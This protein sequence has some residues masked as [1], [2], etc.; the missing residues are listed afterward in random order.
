M[1]AVGKRRCGNIKW[2][3]F[4]SIVTVERAKARVHG[5][6]WDRKDAGVAIVHASSTP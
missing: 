2:P 3:L 1:V 4:A 5:K 6:N